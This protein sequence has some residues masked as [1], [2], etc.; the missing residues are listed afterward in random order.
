MIKNIIFD[1]AGVLIEVKP[2]IFSTKLGYKEDEME[3]LIKIIFNGIEWEKYDCL[4]LNAKETRD[5]LIKNNPQYEK[6]IKNILDNIEYKYMLFEIKETAEYLKELKNA[7]Y[8]IYVLSDTPKE[9]QDYNS[10]FDFFKYVDGGV[11]SY[12]VHSNKPCKKNYETL[13][14]KYNLDP[15]E[16][17]F[18]DDKSENIEAAEKLGITGI[19]FTN[20]AEV[21]QKVVQ[22]LT[23]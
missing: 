14:E 13:L 3:K 17:V 21:K 10:K 6:D 18:I 20:L 5:E 7:G 11:Y 4:E 19:L 16:T 2:E 23:K 9:C 15:A 8:K 1:L 12:E 22:K